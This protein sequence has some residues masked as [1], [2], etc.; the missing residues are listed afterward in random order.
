[1]ERDV[2]PRRVAAVLE[3]KNALPGTECEPTA[4]HGDRQ[5][6][7]RQRTA[8]VRGHVVGSFVIMLV[9]RAFG[10]DPLE[11]A[12]E[13]ALCR[14]RAFSWITSEAEVWLQKMVSSPS[15]MLDS[16]VQRSISRVISCKPRLGART[17]KLPLACLMRLAR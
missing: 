3:Q 14:R 7:L 13:V 12:F 6:R 5:L 16:A 2:P 9:S 11:I 10:R 8:E 17:L 15:E 1:V 4:L